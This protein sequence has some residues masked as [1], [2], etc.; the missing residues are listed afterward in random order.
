MRESSLAWTSKQKPSPRSLPFFQ[1]SIINMFWSTINGPIIRERKTFTYVSPF[2]W[3]SIQKT[4]WGGRVSWPGLYNITTEILW[5]ALS[6]ELRSCRYCYM[7]ALYGRYLN[8]WRKSLTATTQECYEQYWIS[9]GGNTTTK[10]YSHLPPITTTIKI[11]RTRQAG[12]C[13]KSKDELI[14][15]VLLWTPSHNRAKAGRP[16]GSY[17]QWGYRK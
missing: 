7:D 11:R 3:L 8:G 10:E 13:W 14:S 2:N 1:N 5:N 4:L 16:A 17:I 6:S 9:S 15:D 12:H